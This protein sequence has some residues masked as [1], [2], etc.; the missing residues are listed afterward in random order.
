MKADAGHRADHTVLVVADDH[1]VL[2]LAQAILA[3]KGHQVLVANDAR[4]AV[5]IL[6]ENYRPVH[7]VAIRA[8]MSGSEDLQD[9]SL[10]R[11]AKPWTFCCTVDDRSVRLE[12]LDSGADW[13]SAALQAS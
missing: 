2:M 12:G 9:W 4:N 7:S 6:K 10:R 13:E 8:G 3:G 11:G 1:R 5:Q